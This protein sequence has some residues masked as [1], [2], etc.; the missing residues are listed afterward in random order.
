MAQHPAGGPPPPPRIDPSELRPGR[1]RYWIGG[2]AIALGFIAGLVGLIT[3]IVVAAQV[4]DFAGRI[5]PNDMT[6]FEVGAEEAGS[7]WSVYADAPGA[8]AASSCS[9][10]DPTG[11]DVPI[12]PSAV[13]HSVQNGGQYWEVAG[14]FTPAEA[15]EY[16]LGC[17]DGATIYAVTPG[18]DAAGTG[19]GVLGGLGSMFLFPIAG[20]V[21]GL[22]L[23]VTAY[24]GRS[25]HRRRLLAERG[26]PP[27]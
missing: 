27:Y 20:L 11:A 13:S 24:S 21:I 3:G 15:G 2:A 12:G 10:T 22:V 18:G 23:I 7:S 6:S 8:D 5:E 19:L 26:Y 1:A 17:T 16:T 14:S 9:V 4:P 25:R